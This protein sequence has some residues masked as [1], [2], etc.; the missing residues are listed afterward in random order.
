MSA[1][2]ADDAAE[3]RVPARAP[4][5]EPDRRSIHRVDELAPHGWP[6]ACPRR[7]GRGQGRGA[8]AAGGSCRHRRPGGPGTGA[9][10][11]ARG[12]GTPGR[13]GGGT[14]GLVAAAAPGRGR[15]WSSGARFSQEK[16]RRHVG[17]TLSRKRSLPSYS[18]STAVGCRAMC[19]RPAPCTADKI[20]RTCRAMSCTPRRRSHP[21][22]SRR[23]G[24]SGSD[25][26]SDTAPLNCNT[27]AQGRRSKDTHPRCPSLL[28]VEAA[29]A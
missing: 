4:A 18:T 12:R 14:W 28:F 2:C 24:R 8:A 25:R 17:R 19:A 6:H 21:V 29:K 15:R 11:G 13:S 10:P 16:Q 3:P 5:A 7:R 9:L 27:R 1:F 20:A 23:P 26:S 22:A